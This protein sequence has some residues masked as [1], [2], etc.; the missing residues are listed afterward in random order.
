MIEEGRGRNIFKKIAYLG[1]INTL[2]VGSGK[3]NTALCMNL[4]KLGV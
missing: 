2:I 4:S 1:S 3:V